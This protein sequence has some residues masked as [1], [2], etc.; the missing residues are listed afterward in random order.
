MDLKSAINQIHFYLSE[1]FEKVSIEEGD[2]TK[3]GKFFR[4]SIN[5]SMSMVIPFKNLVSG[6]DFTW[7]YPSNPLDTNSYLIE[8]V[9]N[10]NNI[11]ECV[12]DILENNR[13]SE[14]YKNTNR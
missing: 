12:L 2:S 10:P 13:F 4:I 7:Y 1:K 11:G 9:S 5:E 6:F 3:F 8:R 14:D